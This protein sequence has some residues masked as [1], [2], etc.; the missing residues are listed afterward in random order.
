MKKVTVV[1]PAYRDFLS[2]DEALSFRQTL[3]LLGGYPISLVCPDDLNCD[4]YKTIAENYGL[5]LTIERF[6][7]AFFRGI[8]GYNRLLLSP[9]FYQR[10]SPFEYILICQLDA[11]V[12]RDELNEW[13]DKDFDYIG[14][15]LIGDFEDS[16]FSMKMRV[17]N[18]GFSL[19]R[20]QA[21]VDFFSSNRHVFAPKQIARRIQLN[22]KP[23]TRVF[24][25]LLMVLGWRNKP[26]V[27][28]HRWKYNED[29][30]WS[31]VLNGTRYQ[32]KM[33]EIP[34]AIRF[35]FERFPSELFELNNHQLPFGCHAWR[36]Y[37]YDAFWSKF[38]C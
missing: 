34:D 24:V 17:G 8:E 7:C 23:L 13:C 36:K 12:F 33:P 9:D 10:F 20:V 4:Q 29:D 21:Y 32:L 3:H 11:Y 38:I 25:W 31:C 37:Q 28:A 19:R 16:F 27:V 5:I 2:E 18:G 22:K 14:A 15:P 35:S 6:K 1:I 30:F 26:K